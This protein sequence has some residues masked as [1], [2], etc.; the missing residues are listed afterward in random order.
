LGGSAQPSTGKI[1]HRIVQQG[2]KGRSLIAAIFGAPVLT[3][4]L[5]VQSFVKCIR[6]WSKQRVER[7]GSA[8]TGLPILSSVPAS[9]EGPEPIRQQFDR[10]AKTL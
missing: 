1:A 7:S 8:D 2:S 3:E 5:G 6:N 4:V 9:E 10:S